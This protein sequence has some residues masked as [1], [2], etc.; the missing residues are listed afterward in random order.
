MTACKGG[1]VL[2]CRVIRRSK[3]KHTEK[4]EAWAPTA[5]KL[6][7][8]MEKGPQEGEDGLDR[9]SALNP[10]LCCLVVRGPATTY[11]SGP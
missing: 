4:W 2:P 9:V 3:L 1:V 7:D 5:L 6:E 11:Y 8:R 10:E